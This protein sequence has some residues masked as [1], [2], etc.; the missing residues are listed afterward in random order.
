MSEMPYEE[1]PSVKEIFIE[2]IRMTTFDGL[3]KVEGCIARPSMTAANSSQSTLRTSARLVLTPQAALQLHE[4][5]TR[6]VQTL[7]QSGV[8]K[9]LHPGSTVKN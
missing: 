6:L 7:E 1:D 9:R 2:Q 8:V 5:L 3:A 4:Q